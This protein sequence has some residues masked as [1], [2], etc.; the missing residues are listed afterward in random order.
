MVG[1]TAFYRNPHYHAATDTVET[2]DL[3]FLSK[4]TRGLAAFLDSL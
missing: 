3:D 2:L 1:D 4:V